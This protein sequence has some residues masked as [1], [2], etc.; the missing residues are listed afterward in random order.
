VASLKKIFAVILIEKVFKETPSIHQAF[1]NSMLNT[2][3]AS[4]IIVRTLYQSPNRPH[5]KMNAKITNK[6]YV[7]LCHI[8]LIF[9]MLL[10]DL[11]AIFR[12]DLESSVI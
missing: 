1:Q 9:P 3:R 5:H 2:K 8:T 12:G 10:F 11:I 4:H 7:R 6:G